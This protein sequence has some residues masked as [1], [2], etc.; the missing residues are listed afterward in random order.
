MAEPARV[1][2]TYHLCRSVLRNAAY[3]RGG[4]SRNVPPKTQFAI[5]AS[6]NFLDWVYLEWCKLFWDHKGKHHFTKILPDADAFFSEMLASLSLDADEFKALAESVADYRDRALAHTDVFDSID[7]PRL[8]ALIES[9]LLLYEALRS[10]CG[11]EPSPPAPYDL[12]A[13]LQLEEDVARGNFVAIERV[14]E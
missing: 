4:A 1:R 3:Y 2:V 7:I 8:D 11:H 12:R 9:T 5:Q 14:S 13:T 10:Q 6:N